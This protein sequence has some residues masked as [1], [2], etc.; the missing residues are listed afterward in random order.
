MVRFKLPGDTYSLGGEVFVRV[1]VDG[2]CQD[3]HHASGKE[4]PT[5]VMVS[6]NKEEVLVSAE[7]RDSQ[8]VIARLAGKRLTLKVLKPN[9]PKCGPTCYQGD[10][11]VPSG[12]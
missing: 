7:V 10:V 12:R 3:T 4:I 2:K 6:A 5:F 11:D 9:G 1:C 8:D